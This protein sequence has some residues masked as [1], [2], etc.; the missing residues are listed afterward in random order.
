[1]MFVGYWTTTLHPFNGLFPGQPGKPTA[2]RQTVLHFTDAR[3]DK[4]AVALAGLYA[5]ICISLHTENH[6]TR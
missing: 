1:M 3:D 2:E 4:V 6:A 5:N